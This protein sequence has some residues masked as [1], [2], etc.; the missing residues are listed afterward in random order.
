MRKQFVALMLLIS[1]ESMAEWV[2]VEIP[3]KDFRLY[4]DTST[5]TALSGH[6]ARMWDLEDYKTVVDESDVRYASSKTLREYDCKEGRFRFV[7]W[8]WFSGNMGE[9]EVDE[10]YLNNG[11]PGD[12]HTLKPTSNFHSLLKAACAGQKQ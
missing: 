10:S 3:E 6:R 12:W 11:I 1:A 2:E 8:K 5:I 9:G 4:A 7:A